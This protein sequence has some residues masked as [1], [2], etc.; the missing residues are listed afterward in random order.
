MQLSSDAYCAP[1]TVPLGQVS[2]QRDVY[3]FGC[4]LLEMI[5][6]K[7][8]PPT[9]EQRWLLANSLIGRTEPCAIELVLNLLDADPSKRKK[10]AQVAEEIY[11]WIFGPFG[12]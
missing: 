8:P 11:E 9:H 12:Q 6:G 10:A 7:S 4:V 2:C 1:E 5:C 3:A